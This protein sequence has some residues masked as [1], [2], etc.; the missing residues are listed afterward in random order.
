[1]ILSH[2][3]AVAMAPPFLRQSMTISKLAVFEDMFM[4]LEYP[5]YAH[6]APGQK[7]PTTI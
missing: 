7:S 5:L 3:I 2:E 4:A 6:L 1:M